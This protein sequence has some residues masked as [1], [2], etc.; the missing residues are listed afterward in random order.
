MD[1]LVEKLLNSKSPSIRYRMQREFQQREPDSDLRERILASKPVEK[2]FKKMHPDGYWLHKGVG[3]GIDYAMSSSTHFVLSYLAE[4][5]LGKWDPRVDK[6]VRRYWALKEPGKYFSPPDYLTGQSCLYAHNIR[7]FMLLGYKDDYHLRP[8]I[9]ALLDNVRDDNGYLCERKS[10]RK[11]TKSCIRGTLKALMAY[12][13]LPELWEHKSCKRTVDYFLSRNIYYKKPELTEK[14]RGGMR[15]V[16]PFVIGES[17]LE[18]LYALSKMGY[19]RKRALGDAWRE[20]EAHRT[21][22]GLYVLDWHP[23]AIFKPGEKGE[24]NEWVAFYALMAKKYSGK[25]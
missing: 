16:F 2:I 14:I 1:S 4:L 11:T 17:L 20:L 24:E 25:I 19:G 9:K 5:G 21:K 15:T 6:A 10:F 23:S 12:A 8:R 7:T 18:P 3:D 13:E 22:S